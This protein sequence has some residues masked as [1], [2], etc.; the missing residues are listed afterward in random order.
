[1]FYLLYLT[2]NFLSIAYNIHT[3]IKMLNDLFKSAFHKN[4]MAC[5]INK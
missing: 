5:D 1:M 3:Q 4:V 2:T